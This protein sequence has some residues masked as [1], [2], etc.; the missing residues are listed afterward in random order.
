MLFGTLE[1]IAAY[2]VDHDDHR[3]GLHHDRS[4]RV[5]H[6]HRLLDGIHH[7]LLLLLFAMCFDAG[8]TTLLSLH[9]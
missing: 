4:H 9:R 5:L 7:L 2:L 8:P 1:A 6:R 3:F